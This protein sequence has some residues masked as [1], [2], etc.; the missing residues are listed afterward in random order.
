MKP[1]TPKELTRFVALTRGA[2][3]ND[4]AK[5]EYKRLGRK[6]LKYVAAKMNL[7][8]G[9]YDICFN[10]G[11]IACSG[12][13]T[14][15]TDKVYLA[16]HDNIGLGWFYWRIC[17]GRKDYSGGTNQIVSWTSLQKNGID[18]LVNVLN[19]QQNAEI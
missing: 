2:C 4:L 1:I 9:T 8:D 6:I 7:V 10:P 11:G 19:V 15:H 5:Q 16:L 3:Y 14:L 12:D 18:W 17:N 13:H